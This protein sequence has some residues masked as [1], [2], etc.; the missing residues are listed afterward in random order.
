MKLFL[1]K[2]FLFLSIPM[3]VFI[4]GLFLPATPKARQSLLMSKFTK[5]SLL[6][7]VAKPRIIFIAGSSMS[8][9]LNSQIF[10]DSLHMNPINT[11]IHGGLGAFYMMDD[12]A[13]RI[14]AGD[15]VV[16]APEYHQFYG[17]FAYGGEELL[18]AA[19]DT[20]SPRLLLNLRWE[21]FK[22]MYGFVP[23]YSISKFL[24]NQY[25]ALTKNDFYSK[26]AFNKYGDAVLH[27]GK[28]FEHEIPIFKNIDGGEFNKELIAAISEFNKIVKAKG[29]T[30][31]LSYPPF[32]RASYDNC[33]KQIKEVDKALHTIP[34][35][36]I[37][38]TPERYA[39]DQN[40]IF[41][42]PYHLNKV[43]VD[44]RSTRLYEDVKKQMQKDGLLKTQ[45][46]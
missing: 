7:N 4:L 20:S 6:D 12:A 36:T 10:V 31:Y 18:R 11:G 43:G 44:L 26:D 15:I 37:L 32:Q 22:K 2:T 40:L 27:Y 5:D 35:L 34:N 13:D 17:N 16:M 14:K 33:L 19:F 29:A 23:K 38:G 41:D 3:A 42:T 25:F 28:T 24:P 1:R 21:Q 46:Q 39:M 45:A 30:F 8:L 9:G